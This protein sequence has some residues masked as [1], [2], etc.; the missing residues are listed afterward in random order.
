MRRVQFYDWMKD[1]L[2]EEEEE[3][4]SHNWD[5][6]GVRF[7]PPSERYRQPGLVNRPAEHDRVLREAQNIK[8]KVEAFNSGEAVRTR[9]MFMS[10]AISPIQHRGCNLDAHVCLQGHT[11]EP[12]MVESDDDISEEN[13][14]LGSPTAH[15]GSPVLAVGNP[16]PAYAL[17]SKV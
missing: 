7:G 15:P 11:D 8:T 12:I 17:S 4:R 13:T 10:A 2:P 16:P 1:T 14:Q 9:T 6:E 3:M 5:L